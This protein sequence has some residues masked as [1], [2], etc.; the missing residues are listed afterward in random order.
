MDNPIA[1][2]YV[3]EFFLDAMRHG[4]ASGQVSFH[5]VQSANR[6]KKSWNYTNPN[7]PDFSLVE[8]YSVFESSRMSFGRKIINYNGAP[9]WYMHYG[10]WYKEKVIPFLKEALLSAYNNNQFHGGRGR[11]GYYN[12]D[13]QFHGFLYRNNIVSNNFGN[14]SGREFIT[15]EFGRGILGEHHYFGGLLI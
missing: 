2:E 11:S 7:F 3:Q 15:D 8:A 13:G 10:G 1:P 9:I 4:W 5:S 12:N 6:V 14:F